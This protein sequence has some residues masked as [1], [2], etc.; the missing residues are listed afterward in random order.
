[1]ASSSCVPE[2][3]LLG[4]NCV[5][6]ARV[7]ATQNDVGYVEHTLVSNEFTI[8]GARVC[9]RSTESNEWSLS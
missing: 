6:Y 9:M 4:I 8:D 5:Y 7:S 1:M 2:N 3:L